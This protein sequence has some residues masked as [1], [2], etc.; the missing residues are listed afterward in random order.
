MEPFEYPDTLVE[1]VKLLAQDSIKKN[2]A[3][4]SAHESLSRA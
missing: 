3:L 4:V 2:N 1:K